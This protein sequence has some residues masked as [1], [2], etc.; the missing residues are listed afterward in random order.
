MKTLTGI[1]LIILGIA[2]GLYVG[3]YLMFIGGIVQIV[4]AVKTTPTDGLGIAWG[5]IRIMVGG[6]TGALSALVPC[7]FGWTLLKMD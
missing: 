6:L 3:V 1:L 2:I 5:I 4:D 7:V